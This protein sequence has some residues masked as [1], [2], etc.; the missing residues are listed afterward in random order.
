MTEDP[1]TYQPRKHSDDYQTPLIDLLYLL[2][3]NDCTNLN[4][5]KTKRTLFGTFVSLKGS[6]CSSVFIC[7]KMILLL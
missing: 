4:L 3:S 7:S 6:D 2:N 1:Y 5:F